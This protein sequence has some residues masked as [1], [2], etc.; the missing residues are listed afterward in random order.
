MRLCGQEDASHP[1]GHSDEHIVIEILSSAYLEMHGSSMPIRGSQ[2][3]AGD[4][5]C[6]QCEGVR[7]ED[8]LY[9][10]DKY[11]IDIDTTNYRS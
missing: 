9:Y 10:V 7:V 6:S 5:C 2:G 11:E 3:A 4:I 8:A 1:E